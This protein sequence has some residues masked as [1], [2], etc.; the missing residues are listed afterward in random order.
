M[1]EHVLSIEAECARGL[2][3]DVD[4]LNHAIS[5]SDLE[6]IQLEPGDLEAHALN[7]DVGRLSVDCGSTN[8]KLRVRGSLDAGRYSVGVFQPGARA[9]LN[10]ASV[11]PSALLC[12]TPGAEMDGHLQ[13]GYGWTS[14]VI[15]ADWVESI[16]LAARDPGVLTSIAGCK[17]M[18]PGPARLQDL[19]VAIDALIVSRFQREPSEDGADPLS[20]DVRNALGAV[21]SDFDTPNSELDCRS[22]SHY[23]MARRAESRMRERVSENLCIDD[24][25]TELRV[26]RRYLEYAFVDAFG[27]SPSRYFRVLRLHQV[28]RRL[29]KPG[30]ATTV[31]SEALNH[32][33]NHLSLFSTQY[34]A[35][36]GESPS[37][38]L[39]SS[40]NSS[41]FVRNIDSGPIA[42]CSKMSN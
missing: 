12:Y 19:S 38:T 9:M 40:T 35:L 6:I 13:E 20:L 21:L 32:G 4:V 2:F 36:F 15:P 28:R 18:R 25:C 7:F 39:S 14:L 30:A 3:R 27:T 34:R 22:L 26:S 41:L 29:R 10:G 17:H 24:I 31:T 37:S 1:Q 33:F 42:V 23:R 5:G 11:D 16:S 8:R